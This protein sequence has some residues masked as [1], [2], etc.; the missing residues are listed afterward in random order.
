[1][2]DKQKQA[3]EWALNQQYQS[4]AA[5]YARTLAEYIRQ[6]RMAR[7]N[8]QPLT[9]ED[10][11]RMGGEPIWISGGGEGF[12]MLSKEASD[13]IE[14]LNAMRSERPAHAYRTKPEPPERE[15]NHAE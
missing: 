4:V 13:Y 2:T 7:Q 1:M 10:L 15:A 8:P 9:D 14:E 12:W 11:E 6:D 3:Y 5:K